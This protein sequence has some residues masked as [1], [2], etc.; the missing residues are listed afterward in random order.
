MSDGT[1]CPGCDRRHTDFEKVGEHAVDG[2]YHAGIIET[3]E[4]LRC[5]A[6]VEGGRR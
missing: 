2:P 1:R 4:C 5:G 6:T 3:H